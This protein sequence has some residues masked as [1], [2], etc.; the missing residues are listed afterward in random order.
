[1]KNRSVAGLFVVHLI[2]I[3]AV[4][5]NLLHFKNTKFLQIL[6]MFDLMVIFYFAVYRPIFSLWF[7]FL[8][9]F[10]SDAI[11]G[12]AAGITTFLNIFLVK[13]FLLLNE[14]IISR[15]NLVHIWYQFS[16]FAAIFLLIKWFILS[17]FYNDF[18]NIFWPLMHWMIASI[19]YVIMHKVFDFLS[20]KFFK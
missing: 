11:L 18:Y 13:F 6:P 12:N 7:L 2:A 1:M 20:L 4:I 15:D 9:G 17:V 5:V 14:R 19:F 3:I 16:I 10:W 8:L